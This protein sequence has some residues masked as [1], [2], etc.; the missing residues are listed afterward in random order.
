MSARLKYRVSIRLKKA[1]FDCLK[2]ISKSED[3]SVSEY[4]RRFILEKCKQ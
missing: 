1:E 3:M 2:Q 4:V